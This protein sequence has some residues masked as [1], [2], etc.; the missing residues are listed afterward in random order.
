MGGLSN[1]RRVGA[2][3][4]VVLLMMSKRFWGAVLLLFV[5]GFGDSTCVA[6]EA[7]EGNDNIAPLVAAAALPP[8]E[9][10][11]A[12][13]KMAQGLQPPQ[14]PT[15]SE[16]LAQTEKDLATT[17]SKKRKSDKMMLAGGIS[18]LLSLL[19]IGLI[20]D[21][22]RPGHK[23]SRK[24]PLTGLALVLL[25]VGTSLAVLA[26]GAVSSSR[27]GKQIKK[28]QDRIKELQAK[29]EVQGAAAEAAQ[30]V[31]EQ[32]Q[33]AEDAAKALA[34]T[35]VSAV[36]QQEEEEVTKAVEEATEAIAKGITGA[37]EVEQ[38]QQQEEK[39]A[40]EE[41]VEAIAN[42]IIDVQQEKKQQE[43]KAEEEAIDRVV[44][45]IL[46]ERRQ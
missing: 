13:T 39:K 4:G 20:P 18:T 41:V 2:D 22:N 21:G 7:A 24:R 27:R 3:G 14:G 45:E 10:L 34:E 42:N 12:L 8:G 44:D 17:V 26:R 43:E 5:V 30:E 29:K 28:L 46:D 6:S 31:A 37:K 1:G 38:Q 15:T 40:V 16:L 35:A 36:Q 33:S 19:G 23:F 11:L 25:G 32:Q 9:A